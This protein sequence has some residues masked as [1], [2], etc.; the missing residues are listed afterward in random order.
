[1]KH[2]FIS[3]RKYKFGALFILVFIG[4]AYW[5]SFLYDNFKFAN[6]ATGIFIAV[7]V[8]SYFKLKR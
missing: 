4:A 1:M 3:D 2:P 6:I 7:F 8:V 5:T